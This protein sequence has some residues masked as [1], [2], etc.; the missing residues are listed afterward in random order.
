MVTNYLPK[1][2]R[3]LDEMFS[4]MMNGEKPTKEEKETLKAE[5]KRQTN[6]KLEGLSK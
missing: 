6:I 4:S 5:M 2:R 3:I 1:R